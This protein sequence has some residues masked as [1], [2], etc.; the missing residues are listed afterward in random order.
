MGSKRRIAKEILPII[1]KDRK[2]GQWYVE[3]FVGGCNTIMNVKGK[4][5]GNDSHYYLIE[6]YRALQ[7][8]W[9]PPK[10]IT[11]A[12][13]LSLKN[14]QDSSNP[15]LV[16]Y[17]GFNLSF[18]CKWFGGWCR[19]RQDTD[20]SRT[21]WNDVTKTMFYIKDVWFFN[22]TYVNLP[23]PANSII[24]CDPPYANTTGYKDVFNH[25][26]FWQWCRDKH[27]EGHQI[28]ISEYDA[29]G[30]FECIWQKEQRTNI[31]SSGGFVATEK[32]FS[33]DPLFY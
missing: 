33:P 11:E 15:A 23:L 10:V 19:N 28:F 26:E 25:V 9:V 1:L 6:L 18:A 31:N 27:K 30:D 29:P 8:G 2:P 12:A 17:V 24:Y 20:Y 14:N 16:G 21:A 22:E 4:R 7:R 3:P 5:I 32:L 13:Y